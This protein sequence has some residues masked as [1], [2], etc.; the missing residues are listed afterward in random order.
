MKSMVT[1]S[2]ALF[3]SNVLAADYT[4]IVDGREVTAGEATLASLKGAEVLKCSQVQAKASK[5]GS[6]SLKKKED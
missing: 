5:S 1:L 2:I 6:I 3:A 4:F